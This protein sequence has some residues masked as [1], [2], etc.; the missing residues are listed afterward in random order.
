MARMS[1]R[2]LM[3]VP[4][5]VLASTAAPQLAAAACAAGFL[6][7]PDAVNSDWSTDRPGLCRQILVT[8]L[9]LPSQSLTSHSRVVPRPEGAW[10]QVPPEF[11]VVQFH[12]HDDKPR[13][14]RAAL[15][16]DMRAALTKCATE[17]AAG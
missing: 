11:G 15:N 9:P 4:L 3:V 1:W 5:A 10:P 6:T 7:G 16:G 12:Q 8:D 17:T 13:L 14:L 2:S